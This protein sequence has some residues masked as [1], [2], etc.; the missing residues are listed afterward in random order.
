[1]KITKSSI[2]NLG[3]KYW[4]HDEETGDDY[5]FNIPSKKKSGWFFCLVYHPST[6]EIIVSHHYRDI[7]SIKDIKQVFRKKMETIEELKIELNKHNIL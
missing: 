7:K 4:V 3:F 2:E 1:M 6:D 5:T